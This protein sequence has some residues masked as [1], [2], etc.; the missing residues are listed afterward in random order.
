MKKNG[1]CQLSGDGQCDSPDHNA[2]YLIYSVFD[3]LKSKIISMAVTQVSKAGN[4][5]RME[6]MSFVKVLS[7][8]KRK[9]VEHRA[10]HNRS[11]QRNK[12]AHAGE[13]KIYFS[14]IRCVAFL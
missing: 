12:K 1:H 13:R 5:N 9:R 8:L 3:R 6:K 4:S 11:T 10:N 14:T 2:K 7:E